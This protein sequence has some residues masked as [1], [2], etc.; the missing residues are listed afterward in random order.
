MT[1]QTTSPFNNRLFEVARNF[2]IVNNGLPNDENFSFKTIDDPF[3]V[4]FHVT[5]GKLSAC[6]H[7]SQ[8]KQERYEIASIDHLELLFY[9]LD[10][11]LT[12]AQKEQRFMKDV[13][14]DYFI[15][16]LE[17]Y[18]TTDVFNFMKGDPEALASAIPDLKA[19]I[20]QLIV[21]AL[22]I[23]A[24]SDTV[25]RILFTVIALMNSESPTEK[26]IADFKQLIGAA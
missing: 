22:S 25:K 9:S 4:T 13:T 5:D 6:V 10:E 2:V 20:S 15:Y 7:T 17:E 8:D 3:N 23:K 12:E 14:E 18:L 1:K 19:S 24:P 11:E 16:T 21:S 26:D